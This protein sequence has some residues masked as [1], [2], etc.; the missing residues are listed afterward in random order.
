VK[1]ITIK[2][3]ITNKT[4]YTNTTHALEVEISQTGFANQQTQVRLLN[5]E[6]ELIEEQ[7]VRFN[8]V[9]EVVSIDFE[10]ELKDEGLTPFYVEIAP[11]SNEWSNENNI[12]TFTIDVIDSKIRV[13]HIA[14]EIHPDVKM[15][16][17][18]LQ[19]DE[20]VEL[21][22]LTAKTTN[23]FIEDIP[24]SNEPFDAILI[25]GSIPDLLAGNRFDW[26]NT[27]TVYFR[28]PLSIQRN[29]SASSRVILTSPNG[30]GIFPLELR[31]DENTDHPITEFEDIEYTNFAPLSG[32]I[33]SEINTISQSLLN[34]E[35]RGVQ[36]TMPVLSITEIG[37]IRRAEVSAWDWYKSYQSTNT[38]ERVFVTTLFSNLINWVTTSPDDRLLKVSPAKTSFE[39]NETVVLNGS[40]T[41]ERGESEDDATIEVLINNPETDETR[42]FNMTNSNRGAY[43]LEV[44]NIGSGV[45]SYR[46]IARKNSRIIDEEEGEF[47]VQKTNKE[48]V[49]TVRNEALLQNLATQTGG[50][51]LNFEESTSFLKIL[52][53]E[54]LLEQKQALL[55]AY[56]YPV[57]S[58]FWFIVVLTLLAGE[59]L[60]RKRYSL[61]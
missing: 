45:F 55:E 34:A 16:R 42:S 32:L 37:N 44:E 17:S 25:Q 60:L 9:N 12:S 26:E 29:S 13:L 58:I 33:R 48:L 61:P 47:I 14:T 38:D 30:N 4:G 41:N 56:T 49:Q 11:L 40:L 8:T 57:R 39:L 2:N 36:T 18:I 35:Y 5:T 24:G 3:L 50:K 46:A 28:L 19:T 21:S 15:I 54:G 6:R 59:W 31:K 7:R 22:T 53:D 51:Y 52:D 43:S 27:P 10:L 23:S 1:D 20:N